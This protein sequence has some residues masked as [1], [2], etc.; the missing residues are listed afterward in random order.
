MGPV[1]VAAAG[2]PTAA[3]GHPIGKNLRVAWRVLTAAAANPL[4]RKNLLAVAAEHGVGLAA[5][6]LSEWAELESVPWARRKLAAALRGYCCYLQWLRVM[7]AA[8]HLLRSGWWAWRL[9][10]WPWL[11]LP[12][13]ALCRYVLH[14]L[15]MHR[16]LQH[17]SLWH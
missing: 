14:C 9:P 6:G 4:L 17:C 15:A 2:H 12:R 8:Q 5:S 3:A 16:P 13:T 11:V 10:S 1:H 7:E